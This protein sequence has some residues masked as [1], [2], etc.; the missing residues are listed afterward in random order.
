MKIYVDL[1]MRGIS[2]AIGDLEKFIEKLKRLETEL[3]EALARY[4]EVQ[5]KARYD[6]AAYNIMLFDAQ[7]N[8]DGSGSHPNIQVH[9]EQEEDGWAVYADGQEVCFVEFGAGVY[10]NGD[11]GN[12]AGIR[13]PGIVGIGEYGRG[14]GKNPQWGLPKEAG[15]GVTRGTP[16]S[17]ALYFTAQDMKEKIEE[18][19]RRILND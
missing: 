11:G 8:I 19:V 7:G 6:T 4:G 14:H 15:G 9:A 2:K 12:Y 16:A 13:P 1:T 10:Y 18:E 5:A 3:P 17:N